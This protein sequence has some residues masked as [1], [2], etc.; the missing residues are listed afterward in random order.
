MRISVSVSKNCYKSL[1][2]ISKVIK[3]IASRLLDHMVENELLEPFQ[4]PY[5][6]GHNTE[7]A[8]LR[9]HNDIVNA[10]DQKKGVFLVLLD[11]TA[12][13]D[14]VDHDILLDFLRDH[15]GLDGQWRIRHNAHD[16]V[17]T[18]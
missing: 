1:S 4:S 14:T 5:R 11:L 17:R 18:H 15:I 7:T 13:F 16:V 2:F 3:V 9:F 6:A 12:A 10:V 8:L